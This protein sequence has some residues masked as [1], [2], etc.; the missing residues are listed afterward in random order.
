[1]TALS[2]HFKLNEFTDNSHGIINI[3]D[4]QQIKSLILWCMNIGEPLR[5]HFK[6]PIIIT[7]GFRSKALNEVVGGVATSQHTKGEAVDFHIPSIANADIWRYIIGNLD[8]DQLIAEKLKENDANAGWI[9]C[10]YTAKNNRHDC[11]SF[12][13]DGKYVKGLEFI[14]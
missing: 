4:D 8:F 5:A 10:S 2:P 1:M 14:T 3:P 6:L 13:G 7:S 12:L 11:I 9:H